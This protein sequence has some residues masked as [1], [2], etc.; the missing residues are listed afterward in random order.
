ME[1]FRTLESA[2]IPLVR[3]NVDTDQIIPARFLKVTEKV[4]LGKNLFA[5]WRYDNGTPR[6][7]FVLERPEMAERSVLLAGHNFGC[8]SS[9]EHAPWA[10]ADWGIRAIIATSF[11]DIFQNNAM[12]NGILPVIVGPAVHAQLVRAIEADPAATVSIDLQAKVL[13]LPG[14][15]RGGPPV[16]FPVDPFARKCLLAGTDKLGYILGFADRIDAF[17]AG[18]ADA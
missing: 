9:R 5:D 12:S 10:L 16:E 3:D 4:G 13:T 1:P 2:V 18:R 11:A 17:E 6:P 8:G 7:D 15:D 14:G